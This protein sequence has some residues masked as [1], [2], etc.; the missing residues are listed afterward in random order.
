MNPSV[1]LFFVLPVAL[2]ACS[3]TKPAGLGVSDGRFHPCPKSPN[4]VSTQSED[5]KHR[6]D[7]I[8]YKGS[9]EEARQKLLVIVRSM[10]RANVVQET[11]DYIHV[12]F[13]SKLFR[14]VD[15]VEFWIDEKN[16]SIQFRSASRTG[17]SDMGVNRK[18]ME[19]IRER[20]QNP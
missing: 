1:L 10:P 2:A 16:K 4:C 9:T 8:L 18:R 3:G 17:Y 6:I 11:D 12:E 15:D 5:E 13:T 19:T 7:P 20:F 14:F